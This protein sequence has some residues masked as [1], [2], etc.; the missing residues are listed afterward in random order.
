LPVDERRQFSA[1]QLLMALDCATTTSDDDDDDDDGD[2]DD[3]DD[4]DNDVRSTI[5]CRSEMSVGIAA[6]ERR[7]SFAPTI[8]VG[9][10]RRLLRRHSDVPLTER[11]REALLSNID[12]ASDALWDSSSH[13][14][15]SIDQ[16]VT[17][18]DSSVARNLLIAQ[19]RRQSTGSQSSAFNVGSFQRSGL[20]MSTMSMSLDLSF[21]QIDVAPQPMLTT[22]ASQQDLMGTTMSVGTASDIDSDSDDNDDDDDDDDNDRDSSTRR[23]GKLQYSAQVSCNNTTRVKVA[24]VSCSIVLFTFIPRSSF[25]STARSS[26]WIGIVVIF[27]VGAK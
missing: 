14:S 19:Q 27:G 15:T 11:A 6:G 1:Q 25:F 22:N 7:V 24:Q 20:S 4:D 13:L 5:S 18:R 2:D 3:D 17:W 23:S 10:Q 12:W 26:G 21:D 16:S 9:Y 8:D